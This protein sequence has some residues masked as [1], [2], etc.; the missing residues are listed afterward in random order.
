MAEEKS[1]LGALR[2]TL[3]T[4]EGGGCLH[5]HVRHACGHEIAYAYYL[6]ATAEKEGPG[7]ANKDC[8]SCRNAELV[9]Q[10]TARG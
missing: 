6:R 10:I 8:L 9:R 4:D 5:L 1:P 2:R 3:I 7:R